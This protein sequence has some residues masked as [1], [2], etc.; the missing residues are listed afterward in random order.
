M[1]YNPFARDIQ[2]N[3]YPAYQWLRDEA[4]V[5]HNAEIGFWALSRFD[6]VL[7]AHLD[8]ATFVSGHGVTIEGYDQGNDV[9]ISRDEPSHSWHRKLVSRLF[10]PR[11]IADLEP[12][13]RAIAA[14]VLDGARDKGEIDI[15]AEFSTHL[16]MMVIAEMLGLPMETREE[17]RRY[18]DAILDRSEADEQGNVSDATQQAMGAIMVLLMQIVDEKSRNL[19]DDIASLL[20]TSTVRDDDGNE[21]AADPRAG[22]VP[23]AR[24]HH[25]RARDHRQ[26][27]RQRRGRARLVPRP[28]R[29]AGGR[30]V[31]DPERGRGDAAL[32]SRRR[33]TRAAGS[34]RTSPST[35][36]PSPPTRG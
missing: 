8:P 11:A 2:T 26:A 21:V 7:G 15:V 27:H 17:L 32:G 20:L 9:L 4:P 10:T 31:A 36:S 6:D 30:P 25:R 29:R 18:S 33:T 24:A 22:R 35:A 12:K 3:P 5:Y 16:P 14:G 19:G 28:A 34:S 1:E 23:P 13:V